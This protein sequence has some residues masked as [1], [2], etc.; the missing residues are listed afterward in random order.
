MVLAAGVGGF[1]GSRAGE[2]V[3][4]LEL[5]FPASSTWRTDHPSD[6][7]TPTQF[8]RAGWKR[9]R[10]LFGL[11]MV[12]RGQVRRRYINSKAVDSVRETIYRGSPDECCLDRR[13]I[14]IT[15]SLGPGRW[16]AIGASNR[17]IV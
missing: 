3:R 7:V 6:P 15:V 14:G 5:K 11:T 16:T 1:S 2:L 4:L 12:C 8:S 13:A 9:W 10:G 17:V